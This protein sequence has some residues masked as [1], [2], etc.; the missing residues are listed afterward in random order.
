MRTPDRHPGEADEEGIVFENFPPGNLPVQNGE[1]RYVDGSFWLYDAIGLFN[2]RSASNLF[3]S[4]Y[5]YVE[6]EPQSDTTSLAYQ[7][8]VRLTTP[9]I[10]VAGT[11]IVMWYCELVVS[12]ANKQ[13]DA[14][15]LQDGTTSWAAVNN[16]TTKGTAW[17][18]QSGMRA[19]VLTPGVH[20]FDIEWKSIAQNVMVSIRSARLAFWRVA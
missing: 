3:G 14:R 6:S 8:K 17:T 2:P 1:I 16:Y 11:Y 9:S 18:S 12:S 15:V 5:T 19:Q 4:E 20:T 10:A 7:R 13:V